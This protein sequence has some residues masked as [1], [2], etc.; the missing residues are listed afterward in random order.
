[1]EE[2]ESGIHYLS[3]TDGGP[4]SLPFFLLPIFRQNAKVKSQNS[5][6]TC[7]WR[8]SIAIIEREK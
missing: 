5:N 1:M 2:D 8:F 3:E 6:I 7:F 4:R